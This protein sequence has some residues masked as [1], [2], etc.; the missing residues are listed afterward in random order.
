MSG[1]RGSG[2]ASA[3]ST[4]EASVESVGDGRGG[5][6]LWC[7]LVGQAVLFINTAALNVA[8]P[9]ISTGLG[10]STAAQQWIASA[11]SLAFAAIMLVAGFAG[12]RIGY[13]PVLLGGLGLLVA[14]SVL[15]AVS[16]GVGWLIA[17]R[18]LLGAGA[19]VFV[20]MGLA[21]IGVLFPGPGRGRAI[22]AW[23]V[24]GTLGAPLGP[25]IGGGLTALAGW[26]AIF[27]FDVVAFV[28]V[29]VLGIIFLPRQASTGGRG[30]PW[31]QTVLA[32]VGIGFLAA[33]VI[34]TQQSLTSLATWGLIVAGLLLIVGFA[35]RDLRSRAPLT[36]LRLFAAPPFAI[37]AIMLTI[38]NFSVFG[39]IFVLPAYLETVLGH[40]AL[41]GGLLLLPL[42][43]GA[44]AGA[45]AGA[46]ANRA[47][48]RRIG[49][50]ASCMVGLVLLAAGEVAMAL[51]APGRL[52]VVLV[53]GMAAAGLGMGLAQPIALSWGLDHVDDARR[54]AGSSLL[55]TLQQIGSVLGIGVLGSIVGSTYTRHLAGLAPGAPATA[56]RSVTIAYQNA[57][58]LAGQAGQ[59]LRDAAGQAYSSA[60][61]ATLAVVA[62][63][64]IGALAA[65][66]SLARR[67]ATNQQSTAE[68]PR[69]E[70]AETGTGR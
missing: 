61:A 15:G 5:A 4:R 30:L 40:S 35:V 27:A 26:R 45:I 14:G 52:L 25:V 31:G 18:A 20:P 29:G 16:P 63:L 13:R 9:A 28:V 58:R 50:A 62:I 57:A 51:A 69:A 10:A 48:L 56:S 32:V 1:E 2:Q 46:L 3:G 39:L 17:A 44:I 6:A 41:I 36:D 66:W 34:Q 59:A 22:T 53:A 68:R 54:G 64:A 65:V 11:Y 24:A 55:S 38:I 23:T 42:V 8:L 47:A 33:G 43:A 37:G 70:N 12:D 60:M 67:N 7:L 19:G 49:P 21:L